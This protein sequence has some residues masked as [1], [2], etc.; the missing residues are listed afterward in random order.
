VT[1]AADRLRR[2]AEAVEQDCTVRAHLRKLH[3]QPR[4]AKDTETLGLMH[5]AEALVA[6]AV[7]TERRV[8]PKRRTVLLTAVRLR[9][10]GA[11]SGPIRECRR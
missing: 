4:W 6:P 3:D 8:L 2:R 9:H 10:G 1:G 7:T 11:A 5:E